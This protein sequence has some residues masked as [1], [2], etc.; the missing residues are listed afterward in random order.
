MSSWRVP[1]AV[2]LS[3]TVAWFKARAARG[4][5]HPGGP[6][7]LCGSF[8]VA[9]TFRAGSGHRGCSHPLWNPVDGWRRSSSGGPRS[10]AHR[11]SQRSSSSPPVP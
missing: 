3:P 10:Q 2:D 7:R 1:K 8:A 4:R 9:P 11:P 6:S 5:F